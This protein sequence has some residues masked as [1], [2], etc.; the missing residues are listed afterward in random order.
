MKLF[1][2]DLCV[3]FGYGD[4]LYL[5]G[6]HADCHFV[7]PV[8]VP[9]LVTQTSWVRVEKLLKMIQ[10]SCLFECIVLAVTGVLLVTYVMPVVCNF[11][12]ITC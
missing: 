7:I 8:P 10:L 9:M 12:F 2:V 3:L 1:S 5:G 11:S 4:K 6:E